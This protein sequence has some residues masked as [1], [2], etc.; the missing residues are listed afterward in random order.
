[1]SAKVTFV[2][3]AYNVEAYI[4][5]AVR[6]LQAQTVKDWKLVIAND[7]SSDD[8]LEIARQ[9]ASEDG[10]IKV[11]STDRQSGTVYYPRKLAITEADT[12]FVSPLDADDW[13]EPT[14]LETLLTSLEAHT[15]DAV[16]PVMHPPEENG[17]EPLTQVDKALI[18]NAVEGKAC[19]KLTFDGWLIH[20]NGGIVRRD[21]YLQNFR[22]VEDDLQ[23]AFMDEY[24]TRV[25]LLNARRV[26]V[27][28]AKYYY[29]PNDNSITRK[30]SARQFDML[31][32]NMALIE[33]VLKEFG[34]D[35]EE[36]VGIQKQNFHHIFDY[37]RIINNGNFKGK[38]LKAINGLI[39]ASY[40]K[41]D[42][43]ILRGNVSPRYMALISLGLS[44]ARLGLRLMD[45]VKRVNN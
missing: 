40:K 29:R 14:Y 38:E 30:T 35:S 3:P 11:I 22:R 4:G 39:K 41:I 36:Y 5:D 37:L 17:G 8:T 25:I 20:C 24:M 26:V 43:N 42:K 1:M 21:L 33:F 6:S 18:G 19:V 45:S 23:S 32:N 28:N 2:M 27:E 34:P 13:I 16:Y 7:C 9:F 15:A 12:E 10:R 31:K 44:P